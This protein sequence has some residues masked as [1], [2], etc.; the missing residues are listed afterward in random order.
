M[1]ELKISRYCRFFIFLFTLAVVLPTADAQA[2]LGP[3]PPNVV[4]NGWN[5][6]NT[7]NT[8]APEVWMPDANLRAVVEAELAA[9][10]P[11]LTLS[12]D[13]LGLLRSILA[14]GTGLSPI[15]NLTGLEHATNLEWLDLR[16]NSITNVTPLSGL[17]NLTGLD[18][19]S[20]NITNITPLSALVNLERLSLYANT[21][22]GVSALSGMTSMRSLNLSVTGISD[23]SD[24]SG[25]TNL[26][27]LYLGTN[28]ITDIS[29]LSNFGS[30]ESLNLYEN[31]NDNSDGISD[32]SAL[33]DLTSL[34]SLSLGINSISDIS[35]LSALVNLEYLGIE[36]NPIDDISTLT[37]LSNLEALRLNFTDID[38]D[39][40]THLSGLTTLE[41]LSLRSNGLS[42]IS[43][44]SGLVNME[45]LDISSGSVSDITPLA[46]M[47]NMTHLSLSSNDIPDLT[48][49]AG[50]ENMDTLLLSG[51]RINRIISL[52]NMEVLEK[53]DLS[54]N[55]VDNIYAN[56]YTV[57]TLLSRGT[58]VIIDDLRDIGEIGFPV[59][60][61]VDPA[62]PVNETF[63]VF[64]KFRGRVVGFDVSELVLAPTTIASITSQAFTITETEEGD[65]TYA[66][67]VTPT[68][69]GEV[70]FSVA[71]K[72][73]RDDYYNQNAPS[74]PLTVVIDL[75]DPGVTLDV[76]SGIQTDVFQVSVIFTEEMSTEEISDFVNA[77]LV[78]GGTG[79]VS[80]APFETTD[81][82]TYT[83]D[84]TPVTDGDITFSVAAG[85]ATDLAGNANTAATTKTVSVDVKPEVSLTV[86]SGVQNKP[87]TVTITFT[88]TVSGFE[89]SELVLDP[90]T[91]ASISSEAFT[92][93]DNDTTYTATI[94]PMGVGDVTFS[95]AAD[96]ATNAAGTSNNAATSQTVAVDTVAPAVSLTVPSGVQNAAF[97][98]TFTFTE[99][100]LETETL[101]GFVASD[102]VLTGL[103]A[104]VTDLQQDSEDVKIYIAT[105][106]PTDTQA[107]NITIN[108]PE[109]SVTDKAR[110]GNTAA[111]TQTV[112]VDL[113]PQVS[114]DVP[115]PQ[116]YGAF[117]AKIIFSD[118]VTGFIKDDIELGGTATAAI[119]DFHVRTEK[120]YE[121]EI[122]PTLKGDLTI[123]VPAGAAIDGGNNGNIAATSESIPVDVNFV[124]EIPDA[125]LAAVIRRQLNLDAN[126][127]ITRRHMLRLTTLGY[128]RHPNYQQITDLSGLEHA[129][130][131]QRLNL[132]NT[133]IVDLT[134]LTNLTNLT[135]LNLNSSGITDITVLVNLTSLNTLL[136]L[137]NQITDVSPFST[138]LGLK[139]LSIAGNP[140][141]D[142]SP[143][144]R[145]LHN[146]EASLTYV[147]IAISQYPPWDVNEDGSV[148]ATDVALVTAAL[149]QTGNAIVDPHTDV[150]GDQSVDQTDVDLVQM[151]VEPPA[152]EWMPDVNLRR[153]MRRKLDI[154]DDTELTQARMT[155]LTRLVFINEQISDITG[156]EYAINLTELVFRNTQISDLEP[157]KDLSSL[158]S[159]KL[160]DNSISDI[161]ALSGLTNLTFLNI[162]GNTITDITAL[163]SLTNLTELWLRDNTISDVT[164]LMSLTQL[165]KLRLSDNPILDTSPLYPLTQDALS[166]VDIT[167][168][169]YQPWDVNEDGSVDATDSALVTAAL[170]QTGNAIA[171]P[172][173]DVNGDGTVDQDDLTLVMDNL[174][175]NNQAPSSSGM[176]AFLDQE[177]LRALDRGVLESYLNVLRAESDGSLKYER[178]IAMLE[179]ILAATRPEQTQLLVNYPNPFNPE[180]WIP[181][182]LANASNVQ[183][184]I[185]DVQGTVVRRLDLGHQRDGYYTSRSRAAYW[186]GR[187]VFGER[188]ASGIYFYQLEAD[189]LSLLRKM[190]ILK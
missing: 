172:R 56:T 105:I 31:R 123:I 176:F 43:D 37:N 45:K 177:T 140:F 168:S 104:E 143:L 79:T 119:T 101:P 11:A 109:N 118:P 68:G 169:Q 174:D 27:G 73:M 9:C 132:H 1:N 35:D 20:N 49:L 134:V 2:N 155:R 157:L 151:Y 29:V 70:T 160:V 188:V 33:A 146:P 186:D 147:D 99:P 62:S 95:V 30:L 164:P 41:V 121:V 154:A 96:V 58:E 116:R 32:I 166:S 137:D 108:L 148:N 84:V 78:L 130:N 85:V 113:P 124:V 65:F 100:L 40:L 150:N 184:T 38:D 122:K 102:I 55:P 190:V 39:D 103:P 158:E 185:Y 57:E 4:P 5:S 107:G 175:T 127:D 114:F 173:T 183:I 80:V 44:L 115:S 165:Q 16:V 106:T 126:D 141:L 180:T 71:E 14:D 54:V 187:N 152:S 131:L 178:A 7:H 136:L 90:T 48:P 93:T 60:L 145:L 144:Y 63:Q 8:P 171:D 92:I 133:R 87:F 34:T 21:I 98:A 110:N 28:N 17:M 64:A 162:S 61:D 153:Q 128:Q 66:V 69:S 112:S 86:P 72:V 156:L 97:E 82:I 89:Q 51:N 24:L 120:I 15:T 13:T 167:V 46:G 23:I 47:V 42:D 117:D 88:E 26:I 50:M 59:P 182:H 3:K 81:D 149:G 94:T 19:G 10:D 6:G 138:M 161:T 111:T 22:N 163:G 125:S 75:D 181:Y 179:S 170:G 18:L 76:P 159:L 53:V 12:Q 135:W 129:T 67:D 74:D 83:A 91:L 189:N 52:L 142:T 139:G 25:M 77:D 36:S